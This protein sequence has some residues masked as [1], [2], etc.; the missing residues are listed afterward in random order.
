MNKRIFVA[1][2]DEAWFDS[3][4]GTVEVFQ[5]RADSLQFERHFKLFSGSLFEPQGDPL[6]G[7]TDI[8]IW[9][10]PSSRVSSHTVDSP[11]GFAAKHQRALPFLVEDVLLQDLESQ[12]LAYLP[13]SNGQLSVHITDRS[14]IERLVSG[15]ARMGLPPQ[16]VLADTSIL[17]GSAEQAELLETELYSRYQFGAHQLCLPISSCTILNDVVRESVPGFLRHIV[18]GKNAGQSKITLEIPTESYHSEVR[19]DTSESRYLAECAV[20]NH[21]QTINLLQGD[22]KPKSKNRSKSMAALGLVGASLL[23]L[24]GTTYLSVFSYQLDMRTDTLKGT[25]LQRVRE[26]VPVARSNQNIRR[27]IEKELLRSQIKSDDAYSFSAALEQLLFAWQRQRNFDSAILQSLRYTQKDQ[28]LVVDINGID[29]ADVESFQN[30][31][32]DKG[33]ASQVLSA[34]SAKNG[35]EGITLRLR[36]DLLDQKISAHGVE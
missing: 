34:T 2:P 20:R 1:V 3:A 28:E 32:R 16:K 7:K 14:L 18:I 31:L 24:V 19:S 22:F 23:L 30:L 13:A 36:I 29:I 25:L 27:L 26:F 5:F 21:A 9:L 11:P 8:V 33:L 10:V 4:E 17:Q 6:D 35:S 12:H 15:A